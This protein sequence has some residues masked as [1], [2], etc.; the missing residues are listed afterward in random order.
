MFM[1]RSLPVYLQAEAAECGLACVG[2]IAAYWGREIDLPALRRRAPISVQGARLSD[3]IRTAEGLD[4]TTRALKVD[5]EAL[6]QVRLPAILHWEFNHFV[7]LKRLTQ[8]GAI[9]HDPGIGERRVSRDT[10]S[11]SFTGI[12]LELTPGNGFRP[13][14]ERSTIGLGTIMR[15]VSGI[16]APLLQTLLLSVCIQMVLLALPF[17]T[18][19]S[20]DHVVPTRDLDL[21]QVLAIGFAVI[22]ATGPLLEWLR[23][24]QV[25]FIG[26]QFSEQMTSNVVRYLLSLPLGFFEKRSIGD[27]LSRMDATE[28]LRDLLI[29]G[30]VTVLVD[31]LLATLILGMMV[32]YS[33]LLG[34]VVALT[35]V[36][37]IVLRLAF[38]PALRRQ[39]NETLQGKGL[40][41]AE[42]IESMRGIA[43]IKF[44]GK[45][46]ERQSIWN[47][48][49][50]TYLNSMSLLQATQ[51]NYVF[52]KDL[53]INLSIVLLVYMGIRLVLNPEVAFSL[54]AFVAF[55]TYR[56]MFFA[57]LNSLLEMLIEFSMSRVHLERL[58]E[59]LSEDS[60]PRTSEFHRRISDEVDLQMSKVGFRFDGSQKL[61]LR[62]VDTRIQKGQRIVLFGPSGAGKT[63]LLKILAGI[64]QPTD[65]R[66]SL[67][68]LDVA[69]AGLRVLRSHCA[70]VLQGDYL[71]KG[72][73]M[74]NITFFDRLPDT[75]F[76]IQCAKLACIDTDIQAMPM[77]YET[78]VGEMGSS[79]SQ[80]Q[81]QR[82]LLARALYL[83]R[84]I[85]ILDEGTAH[86]DE[87]TEHKV[88]SNLRRLGLT[89]VMTAHKRALADFGT[90][91][92]E[93]D[94]DG[95]LRRSA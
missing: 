39:V 16:V 69:G 51:A 28:R 17:L 75:D 34:T 77:S 52:V 92:W 22:F 56:E 8:S 5:L 7:V 83:K 87:E 31:T 54:G 57:R 49:L 2:M 37:V 84:P 66:I 70:T 88:L 93:I 72:S 30:F 55:A 86:L 3:L 13:E 26:I 23:A 33:P 20:I 10:L 18:Q 25:I 36:L 89:V 59:I 64:Y 79:L 21:L 76:A 24:R 12:V 35:A 50:S 90:E 67:N 61:V 95:A 15:G 42:L 62:E 11:R 14:R 9:V 80:G 44:A 82:V 94:R 41:Q 40:E 43:S 38:I 48:R 58:A 73:V 53:L 68:D 46:A 45:E 27:L 1:R 71:F 74:D 47:N 78:L 91:I 29:N 85:L 60:E 6:G 63:T 32:Y 81:Q 19:L 65:G 4:M